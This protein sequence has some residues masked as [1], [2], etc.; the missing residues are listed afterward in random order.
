M[1]FSAKATTILK[2][3]RIIGTEL[4]APRPD[5]RAFVL[6]IPQ[7]P[8]P[9]ENLEA[10]RDRPYKNEGGWVGLKDSSMINGF[11]I[12]YLE[13]QAKYTDEDWGLDYDYVL[14]DETTRINQIFV[15][16]EDE[17]ETALSQWLEDL[18]ELKEPDD[19]NSSLVN[20]P[21]DSYLSRDER[22]HLWL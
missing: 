9:K 12:R 18:S 4:I 20:S 21:I 14:D 6:V 17:I 1:S 13:H 2:Q 19:F 8:D 22:P 3:G 10:W 5:F 11:E 7:L 15:K 16:R